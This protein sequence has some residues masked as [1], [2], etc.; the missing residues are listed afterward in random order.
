MY[1]IISFI[2]NK[3]Y[4][5]EDELLEFIT[6]FMNTNRQIPEFLELLMT[7]H[8]YKFPE[9]QYF[10]LKLLKPEIKHYELRTFGEIAYKANKLQEFIQF[11]DEYRNSEINR[12]KEQRNSDWNRKW[13]EERY[14]TFLLKA[15]KET[16]LK[17]RISVSMKYLENLKDYPKE[18]LKYFKVLSDL[19][20]ERYYDAAIDAY[21]LVKM[22]K[23]DSEL[24]WDNEYFRIWA[25]SKSLFYLNK[26]KELNPYDFF[27]DIGELLDFEERKEDPI[28]FHL[29]IL[30]MLSHELLE[31]SENEI[32]TFA[33]K[34]VI[35]IIS[36][37]NWSDNQSHGIILE[38]FYFNKDLICNFSL[39]ILEELDKLIEKLNPDKYNQVRKNYLYYIKAMIFFNNN[40]LKEARNVLEVLFKQINEEEIYTSYD[41]INDLYLEISRK[42]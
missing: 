36:S 17:R 12:Y 27:N 5:V 28:Y 34:L 32:L 21:Q 11:L 7:S 31:N 6:S 30:D 9:T 8:S 29:L 15:F 20:E 18:K 26:G 23:D 16:D 35:E 39:E 22:F 42:G 33:E 41:D 10:I 25:L 37:I 13:L 3:K 1:K 2:I 38:K 40:K 19:R 4:N 24:K 14:L